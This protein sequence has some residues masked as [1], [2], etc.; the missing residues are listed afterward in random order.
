[1]SLSLVILLGPRG[2][3]FDRH[4]MPHEILSAGLFPDTN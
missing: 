4:Q 2:V 1:M 3:R